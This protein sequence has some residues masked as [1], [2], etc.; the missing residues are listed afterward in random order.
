[1]QSNVTVTVKWFNPTKGFGFVSVDEREP[2]AFLHASVLQKAGFGSLADGSILVCDLEPGQKGL[3]V[4]E[5]HSV[6]QATVPAVRS[7]WWG[8]S[9]DPASEMTGTV[10]FFSPEKGFGFVLPDDGGKD[11][12]VAMRTLEDCGLGALEPGQKVSLSVRPGKKGPMA[13][14]VSVL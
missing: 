9:S 5:I 14:R 4:A 6:E 1:M 3:Q 8:S 11:V 10:K 7:E 12:F 13:D 2:D